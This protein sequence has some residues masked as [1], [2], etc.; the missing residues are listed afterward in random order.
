MYEADAEQ[1]LES[2]GTAAALEVVVEM[3]ALSIAKNKGHCLVE[4]EL[5][6]LHWA[7]VLEVRM[8]QDVSL[9]QFL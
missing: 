5:E 8:S 6:R 9:G 7:E 2:L 4:R 1:G 3:E